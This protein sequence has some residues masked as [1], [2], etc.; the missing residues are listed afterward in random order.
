MKAVSGI[1]SDWVHATFPC[2]YTTYQYTFGST[3]S[4]C[5]VIYTASD[6]NL[7]YAKYAPE[8]WDG[9]EGNSQVYLLAIGY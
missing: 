3:P 9:P 5:R 7:T 2:A 4:W 8:K 1:A 6:G